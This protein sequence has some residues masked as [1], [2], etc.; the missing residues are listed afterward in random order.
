MIL[1]ETRLGSSVRVP[2]LPVYQRRR[3]IEN[4]A[5]LSVILREIIS[6]QI[7]MMIK[8]GERK[9]VGGIS[10]QNMTFCFVHGNV[11]STYIT[12]TISSCDCVCVVETTIETD[13]LP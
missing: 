9:K 8:Y 3:E 6:I 1:K 2:E 11:L 4:L 13:Y 7:T 12:M 10:N 5:D